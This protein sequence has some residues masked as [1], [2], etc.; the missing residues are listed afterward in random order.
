[1]AEK[2]RKGIAA[3]IVI[4]TAAIVAKLA[5]EKLVAAASIS[6]VGLVETALAVRSADP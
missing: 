5:E 3:D 4:L 1:M 6:D 2:L